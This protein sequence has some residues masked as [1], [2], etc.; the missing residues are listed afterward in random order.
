MRKTLWLVRKTV[1]TVSKAFEM[2]GKCCFSQA[3]FSGESV[4]LAFIFGLYFVRS[5]DT[6]NK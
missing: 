3:W 1:T 6:Y 4:T 5:L 2:L